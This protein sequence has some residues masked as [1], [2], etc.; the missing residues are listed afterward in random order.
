M[1][2][3]N[4]KLHRTAKALRSWGQRSMSQLT[5]QFQV[6]SEVILRLDSAQERCPLSSEKKKLRAFLRGKCLAFASLERVRLRQRARVR[7]LREG[8]A[9]SRYFHM[10]AN[11]RRRKHLIPYLKHGDRTATAMEDKLS[12]AN[13]FFCRLMG[14]PDQNLRRACLRLEELGLRMLSPEMADRLESEFTIDEVKRVV[15]DMPPDRALGPDGFSGL[16]FKSCWD[17]I[18]TDLMAVMKALH[19]GRF[20]SFGGLNT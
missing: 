17:V 5:L 16:F 6:A 12:M 18:A 10:K 20:Y 4:T 7:D 9:N 2:I 8:D 14:A 13:E 19:D 1:K 15:M 11:G 3:L